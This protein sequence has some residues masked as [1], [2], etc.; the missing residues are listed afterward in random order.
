MGYADFGQPGGVEELIGAFNG[1][2]VS[3]EVAHDEADGIQFGECG[4]AEAAGTLKF[5]L[6][7]FAGEEDFLEVVAAVWGAQV[8]FDHFL[9]ELVF[10]GCIGLV[11]GGHGLFDYFWRVAPVAFLAEEER[12]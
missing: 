4:A 8:T 7:A 6:A 11:G 12:G 5:V 1:A 3:S 10:F 2:F 9:D